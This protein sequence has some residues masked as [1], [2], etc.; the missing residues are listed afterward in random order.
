[1][2]IGPILSSCDSKIDNND[3]GS[4]ANMRVAY[5][6]CYER[7]TKPISQSNDVHCR[8]RQQTGTGKL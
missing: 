4:K 1:M 5:S 8:S 6:I 2:Y 3:F 7:K